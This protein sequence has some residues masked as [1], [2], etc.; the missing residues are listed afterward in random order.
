MS[1]QRRNHGIM[2]DLLAMLAFGQS[3][4]FPHPG[5][6][7]GC[8]SVATPSRGLAEARSI[9]RVELARRR[10]AFAEPRCSELALQHLDTQRLGLQDQ[11][12]KLAFSQFAFPSLFSRF[13]L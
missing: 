10:K 3:I 7:T 6:S 11:R 2:V 9:A 5:D 4:R 12:A 1:T 13:G 8:R